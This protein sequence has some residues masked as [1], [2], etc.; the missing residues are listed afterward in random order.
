VWVVTCVALFASC[1]INPRLERPDATPPIVA[2]ERPLA[3]DA[4]DQL[5]RAA[6]DVYKNDAERAELIDAVRR[7]SS[8]PL[9]T[10]NRVEVLVDGPET[11]D[12]IEKDLQAAR[13]HIHIETF[14]FG[15]D[16]VGRRFAAVLAEKRREGVEV[17][18]LY[19]SVGSRETPKAFFDE[20]RR[21]GVEVRE[22]RPTNP[23][24][25]PAVWDMHNRDHRKI[26][27]VDGR[28]GFT[29]GINIDS[30]YSSAS[31]SKPGPKRGMEDGW[32]DTHVRIEGPVVSQLQRLFTDSWNEAG[33]KASFDAGDGYF[34]E[35]RPAGDDLVTIVANDSESDD[36]SLYGTYL[37]A[38]SKSSERLW[39]THAY[40]A[41]N[42][43]L[44]DVLVEAAQ[45]GVD[46]RLIV[47]AF[48][49]S[50]V[51]LEATRATY[52][53]L[54][55]SG[56]KIYELRD[57][58]LHAKSVVADGV[59]SI[60]GSSNLDMRSF[61]HNDEVNAIV[62]DAEFARRMEQVFE[63]DQEESRVVELSSWEQRSL[64]QRLKERVVS[65]FGYWI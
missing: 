43:E 11:Y 29:G 50:K 47:P 9:M 5:L 16:E 59:V 19:D 31:S 45:R 1:A 13:R 35:L 48:T 32:R 8:E 52:T 6:L 57:A 60:V 7:Y 58:L 25:T 46:V 26:I 22:F 23:V 17:R 12:A 36:R 18:V 39:I 56:V 64:W 53:R 40:F 38:F 3:P 27:V 21:D 4:S 20:L 15:A 61:L 54:L 2:R 33:P 44:M 28:T 51:V 24:E 10:G 42:S 37:A 63:Q 30:T 49:D 62:I 34:P 41:P 55:E 65:L 14:I